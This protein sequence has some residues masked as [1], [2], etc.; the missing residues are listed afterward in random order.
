M[1]IQSI[2]NGEENKK[3]L[4]KKALFYK[5]DELSMKGVKKTPFRLNEK[6]NFTQNI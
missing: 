3:A 6:G 2:Q 4:Y 5:E 1:K